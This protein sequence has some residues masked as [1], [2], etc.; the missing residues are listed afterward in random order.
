MFL[1]VQLKETHRSRFCQWKVSPD[2]TVRKKGYP[3]SKDY[4]H[5]LSLNTIMYIKH[6]LILEPCMAYTTATNGTNFYGN[7]PTTNVYGY[8]TQQQ[9]IQ[10]PGSHEQT[11]FNNGI[12]DA[13]SD[14]YSSSHSGYNG[15]NSP[16]YKNLVNSPRYNSSQTTVAAGAP[17]N[18]KGGSEG[19]RNCEFI[20][21]FGEEFAGMEETF[22]SAL[23][24]Y[25]TQ[26]KSLSIIISK[27]KKISPYI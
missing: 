23:L 1:V 22:R 9:P 11:Y 7:Q 14:C 19:P 17:R 3:P 24:Q 10:Q 20:E 27:T 18:S 6:R 25:F 8:T 2:P 15:V 16:R 26:V 5:V 12:N 13:M 4:Y 21:F